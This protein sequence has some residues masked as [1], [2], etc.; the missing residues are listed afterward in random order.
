LCVF[1]R[2]L[3]N[4][5]GS[6]NV[7]ICHSS[8][9]LVPPTMLDHK[10][11]LKLG[12]S[13]PQNW[14]PYIHST[15]LLHLSR[16]ALQVYIAHEAH[17]QAKRHTGMP[18]S[19][20]LERQR[21][22]VRLLPANAK[23]SSLGSQFGPF[24]IWKERDPWCVRGC[25]ALSAVARYARNV[26]HSRSWALQVNYIHHATVYIYLCMYTRESYTKKR[27]ARHL[28]TTR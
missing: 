12:W 19:L 26:V 8:G 11:H 20:L 5:I 24:L 15:G 21:G 18:G 22:S 10:F 27:V 1:F 17:I 14:D 9:T 3:D 28:E 23:F 13:P 4:I 25:C 2:A 6:K 7:C 16:A